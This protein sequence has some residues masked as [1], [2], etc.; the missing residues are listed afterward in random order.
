MRQTGACT[1]HIHLGHAARLNGI[2][3][4]D[5]VAIVAL[6]EGSEPAEWFDDAICNAVATLLPLTCSYSGPGFR[7]GLT[8]TRSL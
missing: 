3:A 6:T 4:C 2:D 8:R 1:R 7:T 5:M